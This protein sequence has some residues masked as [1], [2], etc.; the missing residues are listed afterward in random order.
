[1]TVKGVFLDFGFV[2]GYPTP[3]ITRPRNRKYNYLDWD[4]IDTMLKDPDL[5]QHLRPG[6]GHAELEAFFDREIYRV[7]VEHEQTDAIDPQSN[8]LLLNKLHLVFHCPINQ[9]L[10]DRVLTHL[11]TMK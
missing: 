2:I 1:M 4:G 11:D 8:S 6:V 3:G 7:F 9:H 10:V 5:T